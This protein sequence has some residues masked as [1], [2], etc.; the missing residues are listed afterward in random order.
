MK[1]VIL[2]SGRGSNAR[3]VMEAVENKTLEG[4]EVSALISDNPDAPALG[5]AKEFGIKAL[6]ID[7][8][9][10]GARFTE[11]SARRYID[12]IAAENP[13]LVVL[14]G[15]MRI[16]PENFVRAFDGKTINL[17][18]S[19]L[20][21]YKGKDA[22]KRAFEAGEKFCGCSVHYISTELDSGELIGQSK[23]EIL[24]QDTLESLEAKV[25]EAEH[26]LLVKTI[27]DIAAAKWK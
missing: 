2:A 18:P 1:L 23:V 19:L 26:A 20:P 24:P 11:E 27:A 16:L 13:D 12:A 15:F 4:A 25:H 9:R 7:P 22:I 3:A 21:A 17:H 8:M 14:A 10:K 5:I 6:Y